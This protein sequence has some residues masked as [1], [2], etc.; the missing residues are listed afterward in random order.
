MGEDD[1]FTSP[2]EPKSK[3]RSSLFRIH[4]RQRIHLGSDPFKK[5]K[6]GLCAMVGELDWGRGIGRRFMWVQKDPTEEAGSTSRGRMGGA[7]GSGGGDGR[8]GGGGDGVGACDGGGVGG[9]S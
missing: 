2:Q 4:N 1:A 7:A 6:R 5:S 9:G 8:R 3:K